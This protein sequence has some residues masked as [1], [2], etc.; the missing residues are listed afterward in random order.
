M[1]R[2]RK[3]E[4][5]ES[6][7]YKETLENLYLVIAEIVNFEFSQLEIRPDVVLSGSE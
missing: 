6:V 3:E 7:M 4:V 5:T 1:R 2:R